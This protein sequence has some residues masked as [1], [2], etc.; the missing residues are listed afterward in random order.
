MSPLFGP[1]LAQLVTLGLSDRSEA[2]HVVTDDSYSEVGTYPHVSLNFGWRH[3]TL[4]LG[5]GPSLTLTPLEA[6][7]PSLVVFHSASLSMSNRW[8]RTTVTASE[9]LGYGEVD[10]R[11]QALAAPGTA[12]VTSVPGD[13]TGLPAGNTSGGTTTP[14][15]NGGTGA[16]TQ[17]QP[18]ANG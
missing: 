9:S 16:G 18:G 14:P 7:D 11:T 13:M 15:A 2:R 5:Y 8:R 10:F 3:A 6:K 17:P 4:T 1:I 12:P